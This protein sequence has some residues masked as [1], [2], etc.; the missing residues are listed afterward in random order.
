MWR[1][2][3]MWAERVDSGDSAESEAV[4]CTK[5]TGNPDFRS[6]K[7]PLGV[8]PSGVEYGGKGQR[9][10]RSREGIVSRRSKEEGLIDLR[11]RSCVVARHPLL[12]AHRG[13]VITPSTPEN[14][15]AAIRLAGAH[16]YDMVELDVRRAGDGEPVLFHDWEGNLFTSCGVDASIGDLSGDELSTI[17]YRA[18]DEP[19]ATLSQGLALC[20]SLDLGVM[21]DIKLFGATPDSEVYLETVGRLLRDCDLEGAVLTWNHPLERKHL[22]DSAMFPLSDEDLHRVTDGLSVSIAG[23]YWFGLPHDLSGTIVRALQESGAMVIAAI[24]TFQ[25]PADAHSALARLDVERLLAADIDGF[26]IDSVYDDLFE[27]FRSGV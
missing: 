17:R 18:T 19:I 5:S 16:A 21:L 22:A 13:G 23:Q 15:L 6:Q 2:S 1:E 25:Y 20:R 24:N 3:L 11:D 4:F 12:I 10:Q 8:G 9:C 27:G 7:L 14:S 26:Q